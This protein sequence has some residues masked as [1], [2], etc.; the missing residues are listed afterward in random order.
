M[1]Y[2]LFMPRKSLGE[3][4]ILSARVPAEIADAFEAKREQLGMGQNEALVGVIRVWAE[5]KVQ[6]LTRVEVI[7]DTPAQAA[8]AVAR[9]HAEL[10][11]AI[12][13]PP[14]PFIGDLKRG[15]THKARRKNHT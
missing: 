11:A 10:F 4:R 14:V 15:A 8:A 2:H 1:C 12:K 9:G 5:Y 13:A 3:R 7:Y 6:T